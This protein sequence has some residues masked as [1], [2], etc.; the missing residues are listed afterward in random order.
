MLAILNRPRRRLGFS[1][2]LASLLALALLLPLT[3]GGARGV[4]LSVVGL[5]VLV[6]GNYVLTGRK[7]VFA[8]SVSLAAAAAAALLTAQL[9]DHPAAP[10]ARG[11]FL[12]VF[13]GFTAGTILHDVLRAE[14]VT[15]DKI[16]GAICAYLLVGVGWAFLYSVVRLVEPAAFT[17]ADPAAAAPSAR[18]E[19]MIYFSF[20]TLTTLG[21]GDILPSTPTAR[22]LCWLE[23]AFGQIYLAVLV[24]RLVGLHIT[25]SKG[26]PDG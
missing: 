3:G 20:V 25:H 6:S 2:L 24:A 8:V 14:S 1:Y 21:Y 13:M 4:T 16:Q 23:A 7:G 17:F 15:W 19:P 10:L 5:A 9:V 26:R 22:T 12:A 18:A 11:V